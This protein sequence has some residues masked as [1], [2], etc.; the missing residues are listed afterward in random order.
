[1]V[2]RQARGALHGIGVGRHVG[3]FEHQAGEGRLAP[4]QAPR[5]SDHVGLGCGRVQRGQVLQQRALQVA[6]RLQ[7]FDRS[8]GR[9]AGRGQVRR[10]ESAASTVITPGRCNV[11][12]SSRL[13]VHTGTGSAACRAA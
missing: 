10:T 4:Q 6:A 11:G 12:S 8:V 13:E 2:H 9:R 5:D 3:A 1:M 7:A